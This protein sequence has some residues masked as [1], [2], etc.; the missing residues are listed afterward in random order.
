[1]IAGK[2]VSIAIEQDNMAACVAGSR[3]HQ[4]LIVELDRFLSRKNMLDAC[5]SAPNIIVIHN[6]LGVEVA[7]PF[8]VVGYVVAMGEE[9][10]L[11]AAKLFDA[12]DQGAGE[13]GR[14]DQH[15]PV[16]SSDQ[17]ARRSVR[18]FRREAA[19]VDFVFYQFRIGRYSR[20]R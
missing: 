14:V 16:G 19:K 17:I 6:T 7:Y 2:K 4:Q 1:M 11:Y 3:D 20:F 8:L 13:P 5:H 10:Q 9:H 12:F 18:R 15:V